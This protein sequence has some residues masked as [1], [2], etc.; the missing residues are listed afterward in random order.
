MNED[1]IIKNEVLND[2]RTVHLYYS[3][4]YQ[5]FVAF[6]FSAFIVCETDT[7]IETK[8]YFSYSDEYQMPM[9]RVNDSVIANLKRELIHTSSDNESYIKLYSPFAIDEEKY[10]MWASRLRG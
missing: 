3:K 2:G 8:P 7:T 1:V 10:S 6:G 4:M 5:E 9:V